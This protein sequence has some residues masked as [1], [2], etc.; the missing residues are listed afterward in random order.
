[1]PMT[2]EHLENIIR[3][4]MRSTN[5]WVSEWKKHKDV[6]AMRNCA[7]ALGKFYGLIAVYITL[8][9]GNCDLPEDIT[10]AQ[11]EYGEVYNSLSLSEVVGLPI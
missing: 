2:K 4:Q 11:M 9:D 8:N 1:M 6:A 5:L 7:L 10:Q 3:G